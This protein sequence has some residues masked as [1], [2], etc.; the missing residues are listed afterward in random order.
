MFEI[1]TIESTA[2]VIYYITSS[3]YYT[4]LMIDNHYDTRAIKAARVIYKL[5][6]SRH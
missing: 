6:S 1:K 5:C 2:Y 4:A 3:M